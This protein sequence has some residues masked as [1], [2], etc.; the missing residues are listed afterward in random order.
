MLRLFAL[1]LFALG[2]SAPAFAQKEEPLEGIPLDQ[3]V[4][5]W[6]KLKDCVALVPGD[7][8]SARRCVEDLIHNGISTAGAAN[9]KAQL[10]REQGDL[11]GAA[12]AISQAIRLEP[13]QDLHYLQ[14][15]QIV[16]SKVKKA[17]NPLTQWRLASEATTVFEKA[18]EI[19]PRGYPYRRHLV[20]NK[21]QAPALAGGDKNA[22]LTMASEGIALGSNE[23][24]ML[25]GYA[26]FVLEKYTEGV[27]D[28]DK[29]LAAGVFDNTLFLK[30]AKTALEA[31]DVT[32]AETYY[33]YVVA[34]K[35]ESAKSH[36][37]LGTFY[38]K[39][40]DTQKA[41]SE[42]ETALQ[43]D[44]DYRQAADQLAQLRKGR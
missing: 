20:I 42:L 14:S 8:L 41:S 16:L 4:R 7:R 23:C 40:G 10:L 27:A 3:Y 28:F 39:R 11:D 32:R 17:S 13:N 5:T 26:N 15:G 29:A 2:L 9:L 43:I 36:F 18:F 44:P 22:A 30:A 12:A 38:V 1:V 25:R 33:R 19:N 31:N 24:Y 37:F 35:P 21:L 34:K 6:P